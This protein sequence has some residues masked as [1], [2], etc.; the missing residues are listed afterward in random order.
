MKTTLL[1]VIALLICAG[2]AALLVSADSAMANKGDI[3]YL[4]EKGRKLCSGRCPYS[5]TQCPS[6]ERT[7]AAWEERR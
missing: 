3:C 6:R 5:G 4:N 2:S 7:R 1:A